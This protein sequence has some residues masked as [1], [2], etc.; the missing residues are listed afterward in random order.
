[1]RSVHKHMDIEL[2]CKKKKKDL[3]FENCIFHQN[4]NCDVVL[5]DDAIKISPLWGQCNPCGVQQQLKLAL[6]MILATV[7]T[8]WSI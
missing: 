7:Q 3:L 5:R 4:C 1:M 8:Y 6:T 2:H